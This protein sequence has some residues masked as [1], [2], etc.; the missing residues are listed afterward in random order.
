MS[1]KPGARRPPR[2]KFGEPPERRATTYDWENIAK[3]LRAK[4]GE[5]ARVFADDRYT[6][7]TAINN[8]GIAALRREKGFDTRTA[9]NHVVDGRRHCELWMTYVPEWDQTKEKS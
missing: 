2:L 4:P 8:G 3:Q 9:N 1:T 6:L 5:W 7:V